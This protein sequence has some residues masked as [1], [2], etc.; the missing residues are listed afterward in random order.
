MIRPVLPKQL[1]L[2][3]DDE[4]EGRYTSL[5]E[6]IAAR[7]YA[8]GLNR[9]APLMDTSPSHLGEKLAGVD[10]AGRPRGVT[11]DE[12]EAYIR[13][14]KDVEPIL[15]LVATYLRDPAAQRE[16]ALT[17]LIGFAENL[18]ALLAQAGLAKKGRR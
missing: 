15:Y 2:N 17:K 5:R 3:L 4:L 12:L 11:C 18:P 1:T 8:R 13:K 6:C 9:C 14:T 10:S 16:E 7:V